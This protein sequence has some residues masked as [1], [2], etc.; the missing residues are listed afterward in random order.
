MFDW[1]PVV[2]AGVIARQPA[3][4]VT[5]GV[6]F[7]EGV[8]LGCLWMIGRELEQQ[9]VGVA[10]VQGLAVAVVHHHGFE[11]CGL[12]PVANLCLAFGSDEHAEM[13]EQGGGRRRRELLGELPVGELEEGQAPGDELLLASLI[14][15]AVV[16][17]VP[18]THA[19]AGDIHGRD[20]LLEWLGQLGRK[21]F[22]LREH[23]VFGNDDHVCA[24][25]IMGV[26]RAGVDVQTRVVSLFHYRDGQQLER[27]FYP[28]DPLAWD[29]IFED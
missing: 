4:E 10:E 20:G 28:E 12:G 27:W 29:M 26:R 21:G 8:Y 15:P 19:M 22:W 3:R 24:L 13:A 2:V 16:W 14:D 5:V 25:S 11:P 23:D 18:G 6:L 1:A 9:A 17:H 7:A